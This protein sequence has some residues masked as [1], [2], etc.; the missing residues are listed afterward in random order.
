M[1]ALTLENLPEVFVSSSELAP[2]VTRELKRGRLRKLASRLYT[3]NLTELPEKLVK[4]HLWP[5]IASFF[6]GALI[7]DRTAIENAPAADGSIF[8]I[9]DKKGILKLPG[10]TVK[11]RKGVK[12]LEGDMPFIN[13]LHLPSQ[14]RA[15][16]E[17]M[18]I[19]RSRQG[20]RRT[21]S[22][23][24]IEE[25][26]EKILQ[27]N[28]EHT[29]CKLREEMRLLAKPLSLEQEFKQIDLLIGTLLGTKEDKL[30][31][32]AALAR[33]KQAPYDGA[34]LDLFVQLRDYLVS[35]APNI[36]PIKNRDSTSNLAFFEAYFSNFIEG[37]E[38]L[39]EEAHTIIFEGKIPQDR[40]QDAHDI[41]GTYRLVSDEK[42]MHKIAKSPQEFLSLLTS[43]HHVI[44]EA[45]PDKKPGHFKQVANRAGL[46]QFVNPELVKGTLE[47]GFEI[48]QTLQEPFHRASFMMFLIA[49]VHPFTDGNGRIARVMMNAEL[50]SS[51]ET[52]IIIPTV[53]RNNY[54]VALKTMSQS[55]RP[56]PLV[57]T[58]DFAQKY[59]SSIDWSTYEKSQVLLEQTHAFLDSNVADLEGLRLTLPELL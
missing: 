12:L 35:H 5:I 53:F 31:S 16:L 57:R 52:R 18:Q 54:L 17:N 7:A 44:M 33:T 29:L 8:L 40:P 15:Y 49:E 38:F 21:L 11:P 59:T 58:L 55:A 51:S 13:G 14:A 47:K 2:L 50:I 56:M 6:P 9:S 45:R 23:L 36:R 34:R 25:R 26:L 37:T 22:R 3:K 32:Q 41:I 42:E 4:R 27:R 10:I 30:Q 1:A 46:T 39:V 48:Y 28:G 19:S 43:R 20:L 24:E